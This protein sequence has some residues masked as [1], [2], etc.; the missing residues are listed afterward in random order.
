MQTTA[1]SMQEMTTQSLQGA[2][3]AEPA[4]RYSHVTNKTLTLLLFEVLTERIFCSHI[5]D[6]TNNPHQWDW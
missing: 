6:A 4:W 3:S 5:E 1:L 2:L